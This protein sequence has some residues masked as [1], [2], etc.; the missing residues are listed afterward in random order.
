MIKAIFG[1]RLLFEYYSWG[2]DGKL[3]HKGPDIVILLGLIIS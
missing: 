3:I 2:L 1:S